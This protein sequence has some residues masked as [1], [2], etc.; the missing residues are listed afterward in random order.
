MSIITTEDLASFLR[1]EIPTDDYPDL[2]NV[3]V[4]AES[5]VG[6]VTGRSWAV[7][8][9]TPS[10]RRYAPRAMN[11]DL[12]RIHD[13]VSV[14][15]VTNDGETVPVWSTSLGGYQLEPINGLDWAG[16]VRPYES[17]R[18]IGSR[19]KFDSYRAT[20][21]VTAD[22]GWAALPP[23]VVRATFVLAR[24][25]WEFRNAENTAGLEAFV[26]DKAKLLLKG[27][28]R[29]EAKSGIGGPI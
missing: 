26:E 4:S 9:G 2:D 11:Q 20:V 27:Y 14:T 21:A 8:T 17:I 10:L 25:M 19:W 28:R 15:S 7:A 24:D 1:N 29:E 22:W 16:E 12:I 6:K 5:M 23:Q 13:C 18:Y 3:R